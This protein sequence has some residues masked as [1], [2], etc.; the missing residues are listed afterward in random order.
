MQ[1][2]GLQRL[3]IYLFNQVTKRLFYL[4]ELT[5]S[6]QWKQEQA[7]VNKLAS[8]DLLNMSIR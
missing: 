6:L 3:F 2:A 8:K 7:A 1:V 4:Q 5:A